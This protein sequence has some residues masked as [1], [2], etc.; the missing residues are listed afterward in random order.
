M[1]NQCG[2]TLFSGPPAASPAG[3]SASPPNRFVGLDKADREKAA[4]LATT[5]LDIQSV[6]IR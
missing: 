6:S 1:E 3:G 5:F 2:F 4:N